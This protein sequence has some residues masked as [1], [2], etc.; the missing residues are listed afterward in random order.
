M[1]SS[2]LWIV[3][4]TLSGICTL[5]AQEPRPTEPARQD[6]SGSGAGQEPRSGQGETRGEARGA[7]QGESA[8]ASATAAARAPSQF[9]K[10]SDLLGRTVVDAEVVLV[11]LRGG[12]GVDP[13]RTRSALVDAG[14]QPAS[15]A[16]SATLKQGVMAALHSLWTETTA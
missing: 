9:R 8:D 15:G 4:M 14:W 3:T 11:D 6:P 7:N 16:A 13:E 5:G 10:P 12:E 1:K 2:K